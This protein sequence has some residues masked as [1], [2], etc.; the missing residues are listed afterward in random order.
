[1]TSSKPTTSTGP[2]LET[3]DTQF[4]QLI[5]QMAR[6]INT[7][8]AGREKGMKTPP[9]N[10]ALKHTIRSLATDP[11]E[12]HYDYARNRR[13]FW[14]KI[15][16][17]FEGIGTF[18]DRPRAIWLK[19]VI[20]VVDDYRAQAKNLFSQSQPDSEVDEKSTG[21]KWTV[22][23][24]YLENGCPMRQS[25]STVLK[26]AHQDL[27]ALTASLI[28]L[29]A[30]PRA[31]QTSESESENLIYEMLGIFERLRNQD[32]SSNKRLVYQASLT[33]LERI[34]DTCPIP[35]YMMEFLEHE[36]TELEA[37]KAQLP[38]E[39]PTQAEEKVDE[40]NEPHDDEPEVE[41]TEYEEDEV[42][43]QDIENEM[44]IY[45]DED[46]EIELMTRPEGY[47]NITRYTGE[48][49]LK[50]IQALSEELN[51][52]IE[53]EPNPEQVRALFRYCVCDYMDAMTQVF[54]R[55]TEKKERTELGE[56]FLE[57]LHRDYKA[58]FLTSIASTVINKI[59]RAV[60]EASRDRG[61]DEKEI[62]R[63]LHTDRN[64]FRETCFESA[65]TMTFSSI[66]GRKSAEI[67]EILRHDGVAQLIIDEEMEG[68]SQKGFKQAIEENE[69]GDEQDT[70]LFVMSEV[71]H[72]I[73]Y[74][75]HGDSDDEEVMSLDVN[76]VSVLV[77]DLGAELKSLEEYGQAIRR[78]RDAQLE[79]IDFLSKTTTTLSLIEKEY[80]GLEDREKGL[81]AAMPDVASAEFGLW[82]E[83]CR[84][85]GEQKRKL[86][87]SAKELPPEQRR[88]IEKERLMLEKELASTMADIT[89]NDEALAIIRSKLDRIRAICV[90]KE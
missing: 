88:D 6:D 5:D 49:R 50:E 43:E 17:M 14:K 30:S 87:T 82:V 40:K 18:E 73:D 32:D 28:S 55:L 44:E 80:E 64:N 65:S 69:L 89:E 70:Y 21:G 83:A 81:R 78:D 16:Q 85:L 13:E 7:F 35:L 11:P 74:L 39:E 23:Q 29:Y 61:G 31:E 53:S 42:P 19:E 58:V 79:E 54:D 63:Y 76:E 84:D 41:V 77:N 8:G 57:Y 90:D 48:T 4:R 56:V 38:P 10:R 26:E 34:I 15:D 59:G 62:L 46:E 52:A 51:E 37:T 1:M 68:I 60:I 33:T 67:S 12:G 45:E 86:L 20:N 66:M 24:N 3:T 36:I 9:Q 71:D 22:F 25:D 72:L 27:H 2:D 47:G 75:E